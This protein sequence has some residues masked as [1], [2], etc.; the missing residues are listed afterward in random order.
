MAPEEVA[1]HVGAL[2][3]KLADLRGTLQKLEK[4][5]AA[6]AGSFEAL[7]EQLRE[8]EEGVRKEARKER[9][10]LVGAAL[11]SM[12]HL[13]RYLVEALSGLREVR[14]PPSREHGRPS[15]GHSYGFPE[16]EL[17]VHLELPPI[18][19]RETPASSSEAP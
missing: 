17:V 10:V 6:S 12:S 7:Q 5:V 1:G 8:T 9:A 14:A 2:L 4:Q 11:E 3:Q 18:S 19:P 16:G 13:R 15:E